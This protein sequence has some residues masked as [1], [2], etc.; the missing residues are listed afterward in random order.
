M[1]LIIVD[2]AYASADFMSR[3]FWSEFETFYDPVT[4]AV[5][6]RPTSYADHWRHH[7]ESMGYHA[8][9][10]GTELPALDDAREKALVRSDEWFSAAL[11]IISEFCNQRDVTDAALIDIIS[12]YLM[13]LTSTLVPEPYSLIESYL[14][15]CDFS[16]LIKPE[17]AKNMPGP[18]HDGHEHECC[19]TI[20]INGETHDVERCEL[21][22]YCICGVANPLM[23]AYICRLVDEKTAF[24]LD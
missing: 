3:G 6:K 19:G 17:P 24:G 5:Y 14:P 8:R 18:C 1:E 4:R 9:M 22:R 13:T 21:G 16:G 2:R 15:A 20:V 11:K 23:Q 10:N 12:N 7:P